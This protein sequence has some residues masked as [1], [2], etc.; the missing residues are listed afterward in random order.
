MKTTEV[1]VLRP[2]PSAPPWV[3]RPMCVE[4]T[5]IMKPN[6]NAVVSD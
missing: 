1:G 2:T 3:M 6:T 5:G 4:M